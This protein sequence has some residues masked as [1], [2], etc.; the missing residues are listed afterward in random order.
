MPNSPNNF[1]DLLSIRETA[2]RCKAERV[3]LAESALRRLVATGEL[4]ALR[5]GTKHLIYYPNLIE[6]LRGGSS[7][8]P[9]DEREPSSGTVRKIEA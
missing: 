3:P 2:A 1:D 4:P 9:A 6:L 5:S 8:P 7:K